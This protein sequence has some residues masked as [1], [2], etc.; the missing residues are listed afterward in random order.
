V[1][2][3]LEGKTVLDIGAWNGCF[4][5]ECA[6][7]GVD[8]V[9]GL[10]P[11]D[12]ETTGFHLLKNTLKDP[13]VEYIRGSVYDLDSTKIATFDIVLFLGVIY[14]LRYPLLALDKI[15]DVCRETL[16]VES[17]VMDRCFLLGSGNEA[18]ELASVD[19][20][21]AETAL[22]QFYQYDELNADS[23]NWFGPNVRALIVAV[24]SAGF[25]VTHLQTWGHRA[26]LAAQKSER[27]FLRTNVYE[28]DPIVARS[29]HLSIDEGAL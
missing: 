5:F 23:S 12:P 14:H 21:L 26:A 11:D 17:F 9:L 27:E 13:K 7:R 4:S 16:Y 1:P 29:V 6:R 22:W 10:G 18:H 19:P 15:F 8:Y 28:K 24:E 25:Q 3:N 20:R 2:D